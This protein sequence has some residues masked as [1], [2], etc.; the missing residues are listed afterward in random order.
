MPEAEQRGQDYLF[1]MR[2]TKNVKHAIERRCASRT[3]RMPAADGKD[4]QLRPEGW[5]GSA[6][7]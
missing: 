4:G 7:S 2:R 5:S 6:A 1:K 3:G